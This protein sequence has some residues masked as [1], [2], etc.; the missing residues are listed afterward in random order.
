MLKPLLRILNGDREE[1]L[2]NGFSG[3]CICFCCASLGFKV[4]HPRKKERAVG[5]GHLELTLTLDLK[6]PSIRLHTLPL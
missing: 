2:S 3:S 4:P 6:R 5:A 1:R